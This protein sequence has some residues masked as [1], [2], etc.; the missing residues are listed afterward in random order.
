MGI[1]SGDAELGVSSP[2]PAFAV[3]QSVSISWKLL[4]VSR[5]PNCTAT[6]E[7]MLRDRLALEARGACVLGPT[8]LP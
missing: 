7:G 4:P 6:A 1:L 8:G 3:P 2:C 5:T